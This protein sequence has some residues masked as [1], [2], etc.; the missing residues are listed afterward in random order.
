M[1]GTADIFDNERKNINKKIRGSV[2]FVGVCC[3][4][5]LDYG[6]YSMS[7]IAL[8]FMLQS[9]SLASLSSRAM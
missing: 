2:P 1:K 8:A 6:L 9:F 4:G 5:V 3:H 7:I